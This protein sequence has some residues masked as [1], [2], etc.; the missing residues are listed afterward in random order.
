MGEVEACGKN[1]I[2]SCTYHYRIGF[3][4]IDTSHDT[5]NFLLM[6]TTVF[7]SQDSKEIYCYTYQSK[8][9]EVLNRL[10]SSL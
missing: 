10:D 3:S 8:L 6:D 2:Q 1:Q 4:N 5:E 9:C 7:I